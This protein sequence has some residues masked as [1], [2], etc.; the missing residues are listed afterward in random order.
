MTAADGPYLI[1]SPHPP[2]L[3]VA[4]SCFF[5]SCSICTRPPCCS[6]KTHKPHYCL[7]AFALATCNSN[8]QPPTLLSPLSLNLFH[9]SP[10]QGA[11]S[12][13]PYL[14]LLPSSMGVPPSLSWL[15]FSPGHFSTSNM[16]DHLLIYVVY[17]LSSSLNRTS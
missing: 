15:Y 8:T 4:I 12:H 17:S 16:P 6:G 2:F 3:S 9:M 11:L 7:R 1:R 10:S 13:L 14:Q 5:P